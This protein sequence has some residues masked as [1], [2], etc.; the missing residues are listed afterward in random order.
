MNVGSLLPRHARL[1]P[2][3]P[4]FVFEGLRLTFAELDARV[5]QLANAILSLGLRKGDRLAVILP[6]TAELYESYLAAAKTGVVIVPL[7]PLLRGPGLVSLLNDSGSS[8]V[9][10]FSDLANELDGV[11]RDLHL[12]PSGNY[13]LIDGPARQGFVSYAKLVAAQST[14]PP[15]AVEISG[16]DPFNIIY[17]SGTTGAPKGIVHTHDVRAMYCTLFSASYRMTPESVVLHAGSLVFNGALVTLF[18]ALFLGAKYVLHRRFD[19]H[20]FV[21]GIAEERATHVMMVPSQLIAMMNDP[22]FSRADLASLE[23]ICTVGAPLHQEHKDR[24]SRMLPD[25][26]Y[27]L[28]GLTEGFVTILDRTDYVR[29]PGSVGPPV[30]FCDMRIVGEDGSNLPPREVG[31]IV[32]RGPILMP[33]YYKRPD[34]T[35]QAIRDGW[36]FTGDMGYTDDEGYLYLVDRKKDLIISGGVNIFP[37]DIEEVMAQ[38]PAV[39]EVAVFGVP[40]EKWGEAPLAAVILASPGA[41]TESNLREWT[42]KHVAARFQQ[43][44]GVVIM[45]DFP[46]NTAGKTLKRV[47]RD[48]YWPD[49]SALI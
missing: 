10:S 23:M 31:E 30:H 33:G 16:T 25:V 45:D 42:N 35:A 39:R 48:Q 41:A 40:D 32:G 27:E 2:D 43:I 46:R 44:K 29:K 36:L 24:L 17:S 7:S 4:A 12:I 49:K 6:N 3:R 9:I 15:P 28:Y 11:R 5:N 26:C 34:L 19:A 47:M 22:G 38:H 8:L 1:T 21:R 18:P 13:L 37:R 20:A 14:D